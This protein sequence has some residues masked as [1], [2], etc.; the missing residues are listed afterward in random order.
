MGVMLLFCL[1]RI[2]WLLAKVYEQASDGVLAEA[3][4]R[5]AHWSEH[6]LWMP[7]IVSACTKIPT[8]MMRKMFAI[9]FLR[10]TQENRCCDNQSVLCLREG[11]FSAFQDLWMLV[12][13]QDL[14][15]YR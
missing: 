3:W 4:H 13:H 6:C 2:E 8:M 14:G 9:R 10:A 12:S 5:D 1:E 11:K 15:S 7:R